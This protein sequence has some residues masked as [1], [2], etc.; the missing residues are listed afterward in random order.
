[1][2]IV[3]LVVGIMMVAS[4]LPDVV[5]EAASTAYSDTF[6]VVTTSETETTQTLSHD[7]YYGDTRNLS[8]TSNHG[9]DTPT[10]T[11]YNSATKEVTVGGLATSQ[12]RLLTINY[13]K[14]AHQQYTGFASFLRL[15]PFL[16]LIGLVITAL[17]G[18]FSHMKRE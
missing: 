18:L 16:A 4:L 9:G 7:H 6:T 8:A 3:G 15:V 17:W 11:G 1:L 13:L 14:E 12:T 2:A 5:D 10:I